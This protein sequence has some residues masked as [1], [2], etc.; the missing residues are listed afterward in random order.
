MINNLLLFLKGSMIM[1]GI[2]IVWSLIV[3][4]IRNAISG[5]DKQ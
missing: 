2:V 1:L 4:T 3:V 5:S